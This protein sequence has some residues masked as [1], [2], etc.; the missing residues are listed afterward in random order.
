ME[1]HLRQIPESTSSPLEK[2][3]AIDGDL[4]RVCVLHLNAKTQLTQS[5]LTGLEK[6]LIHN[7]SSSSAGETPRV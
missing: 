1:N 2:M 3:E 7:K 6:A 5:S 4:W